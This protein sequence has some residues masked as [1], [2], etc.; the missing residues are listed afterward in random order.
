MLRHRLLGSVVARDVFL[1]DEL[2]QVLLIL[3]AFDEH[4]VVDI[5]AIVFDQ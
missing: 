4:S 5:D 1:P 3:F 2:L